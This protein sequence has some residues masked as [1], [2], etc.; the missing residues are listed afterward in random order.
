[1]LRP[2]EQEG[3][4]LA[5]PVGPVVLDDRVECLKPLGGLYGVNVCAGAVGGMGLDLISHALVNT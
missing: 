3:Q 2:L 4:Q 1:M 5:R